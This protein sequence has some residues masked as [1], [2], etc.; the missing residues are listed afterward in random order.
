M[1]DTVLVAQKLQNLVTKFERVFEEGGRKTK[2]KV[3]KSRD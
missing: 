3:A 2:I 1:D